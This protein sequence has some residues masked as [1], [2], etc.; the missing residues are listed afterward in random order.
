MT[1]SNK[2]FL[3]LIFLL[4]LVPRLV[5]VWLAH[6]L[7]IGLDDMFQYDM[8]ARSLVAGDGYRWYAQDDL[9]LIQRYIPM[10][11][12]DDLDPRGVLSSHRGPGYPGFLAIIYLLFGAGEN[13]LFF[14]RLI[15]AVLGASLA[16]LTW[17]LSKSAGF[18]E[19]VSRTASIWIAFL[20]IL[21]VFPLA[22]AS[23]NLFIFLLTI[24]LALTLLAEEREHP[25]AYFFTGL[26][27]GLTALVRSIV[28]GYLVLVI[29]WILRKNHD[30]RVIVRS[31]GLLVAGF[32]L[33]TIPWMVR[34]TLLHGQFS[35]LET[36]LGYNLY[37]GY[38]PESTG[39]FKYGISLDLLPI[40]DD[41]ERNSL[42]ME[43]FK[44]FVQADPGRVPWLMV[45]KAGYLWG[46]ETRAITYFYSNG[47]LGALPAG[48]LGLLFALAILP[49]MIVAP[50]SVA[51]AIC[52]TSSRSK[53]FL[54][55][56]VIYYTVIH[57]LVLAE[58]RFS[59]P[60]LPILC[61]FAAY[62]LLVK[63]WRQAARTRRVFAV[64]LIVLL[65]LNWSYDL[66]SEGDRIAMLFGPDGHH[67]WLDY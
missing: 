5:L 22:L 4:G 65:M 28:A 60:F 6:D 41:A 64:L 61:I 33:I 24:A 58:P 11:L 18:N 8:L 14:V 7:P 16:P 19:R 49:F 32:A 10:Q 3:W 66:V 42:G 34:N 52:G 62:G 35:W 63:P 50:L 55:S 38:H 59:V 9:D 43:G 36:S 39:T 25:A 40:L 15:Q 67:L 17:W 54:I 45:R 46:L 2:K 26:A 51:G 21:V 1:L 31:A 53:L 48:V 13:R 37:L 23:E 29:V 57:M 27:F 30:R 44:Q 47:L 20:P 56:F 12:P